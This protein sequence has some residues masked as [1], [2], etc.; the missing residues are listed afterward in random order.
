VPEGYAVEHVGQ[1]TGQ[2]TQITYGSDGRLYAALIEDGATRS[3]A[4]YAMDADG[5]V[6]RYSEGLISPIGIAFQP[7]TD[8]L[9]VSARATASAGGGIWRVPS[10]GGAPIPVIDNLP[11]C[12]SLIDNQPNGMVF[13]PDGYLYIG[14]GALTDHGEP[15]NP[16]IA[17]MVELVPYE[18]SILRIQPHTGTIET[19]ASGLRN[20]YDL[21]FDSLGQFYATDQ[22]LVSGPGDRVL[23][24]ERGG[25]Y[26]WPFWSG[27]GCEGCPP[28]RG[29]ITVSDDLFTF[30]DMSI[31][32]GLVA[33][34]GTQFP[35]NM[36]DTLFVVLWNGGENAQQVVHIDPRSLPQPTD[37]NPRPLA[38][39][40]MTGLIRPIDIAL[41]PDG[42]LVVADFIYGHV[43]RVRYA[44]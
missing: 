22:G 34:T 11:C 21:T 27:R 28:K 41:A 29:G 35:E 20:P 6:E 3:G 2:P 33:Y 12:Y 36:F 39:S 4:I 37:D 43:W 14:V 7:G 40:F 32:R 38:E 42:T 23:A 30:P 31:P 25:H 13:G 10:G 44:P 26:G 19:I 16:R 24:V 15:P 1:F 17:N 9:Y 8:V 5:T 18:A